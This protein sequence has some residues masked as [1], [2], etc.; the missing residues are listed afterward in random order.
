MNTL[1]DVKKAD[2]ETKIMLYFVV[3]FLESNVNWVSN[4]IRLSFGI[5]IAQSIKAVINNEIKTLVE[6]S[7][8]LNPP[9]SIRV[10]AYA[11]SAFVSIKNDII[12]LAK[13]F[14]ESPIRINFVIENLEKPLSVITIT[15][16][17][18]APIKPNNE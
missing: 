16:V 1:I 10:S 9:V 11:L 2:N 3:C 14:V 8:L 13:M 15:A 4:L 6:I 5:N 18:K 17:I 7:A 12:E